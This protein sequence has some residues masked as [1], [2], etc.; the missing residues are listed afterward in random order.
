M[1]SVRFHEIS[2]PSGEPQS[3]PLFT[4]DDALAV[5][6]PSAN[7]PTV[8]HET[9][10][11]LLRQRRLPKQIVV[12]VPGAEHVSSDT[13]SL[14]EVTILYSDKG[15][16][17]QRNRAVTDLLPGIKV[18]TFLDDDVELH[19]DYLDG[20]A[21]L[22]REQ[23]DV[24]L[25]GGKVLADGVRFGGITREKAEA[26]VAA[27]GSHAIAEIAQIDAGDAYGCNMSVRRDVLANVRFDERLALYGLLEDRDFAYRCSLRGR[28]VIAG[29]C[30][31]VHLG[32]PSGRIS[33]RQFGF[34]QMINPIYLWQKGSIT[35]PRFLIIWILRVLIVNAT[36][37]FVPGQ[38]KRRRRFAGNLR[39]ALSVL[40]GRV[41]P[42]DIVNL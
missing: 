41:V 19:E 9:L 37:A 34:A 40:N 12:C 22:F 10:L 5:I 3:T 1:P 8:L 35:S 24:V 36:L 7:R 20:I 32:V 6:I 23:Q 38:H 16:T 31:V 28:L 42:E 4:R 13:M 39:A 33:E 21:R 26:I 18:V 27:D 2:P 14:P 25:A 17:K 11:S 15:L 30:R 29:N